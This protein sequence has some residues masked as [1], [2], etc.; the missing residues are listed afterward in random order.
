MK[1]RQLS[2]SSDEDDDDARESDEKETFVAMK[3]IV[4]EMKKEDW[5]ELPV[6]TETLKD[7]NPLNKVKREMR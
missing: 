4:D 5:Y 6:M 2:V 3:V 7:T 1:V